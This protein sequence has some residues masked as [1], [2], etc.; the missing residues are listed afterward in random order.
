MTIIADG[1]LLAEKIYSNIK[2]KVDKLDRKPML[3]VIITNDNEAGKIYVRNKQRACEKTGI[4]SKTIEFDADVSEN[5]LINKIQDLNN[6]KNVDAILVQLPLPNHIDSEKILNAISPDKDADGFHYINAGKMFIGQM[7][8]TIACTPKGIIR[9]LDEYKIQ[10]SGLNAVVI[11]R[12]NIVGKPIS[13]LLL[14]RNATVTTCHSKTK[15]LEYYT[16][17]ADLIVCAIGKPKFL[18]GN[19]VKDGVIIIDVGITRLDTGKLSGDVDFES[20]ASKASL[21]TPV[22]GGVGPMTVAMLIQN[23]L[24]L[25]IQYSE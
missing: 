14:Q 23:T 13:Q 5:T 11:G 22:P 2:A 6:D 17:N 21:I 16:K 18:T 15:N 10:I 24:D 12:S 4:Q 8:K 25:S 9:L 19:M 1:K 3:A 7:P 20:V